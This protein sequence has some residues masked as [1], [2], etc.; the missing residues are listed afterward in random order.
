MQVFNY[1]YTVVEF[2]LCDDATSLELTKICFMCTKLVQSCYKSHWIHCRRDS[3]LRTERG[4]TANT[5]RLMLRRK[6][7]TLEFQ[8]EVVQVHTTCVL[9][10]LALRCSSCFC[11]GKA[12]A[13]ISHCVCF[14]C[15]HGESE[16]QPVKSYLL[17]CWWWR[18]DWS[19]PRLTPPVVTTTSIILCFSKTGWPRFT[20]KNSQW[21]SVKRA[22]WTSR[23]LAI[24]QSWPQY[25]W[26]Q[27]LGQ[28]VYQIWD[29]IWLMCKLEWD[30]ALLMTA[31]TCGAV[32]SMPAF[33]PQEDIVN[34]HHG[35]D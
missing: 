7:R 27:N 13:L 25:S 5:E 32:V 19:F 30:G 4:V 1:C 31:L 23:F 18:Y 3:Q 21:N 11:R 33:E 2:Y 35:I 24:E 12:F 34:I 9:N 10:V 28:W 15:A 16:R 14:A 6:I 17:V 8:R 22:I 29:G 26:L 20:W